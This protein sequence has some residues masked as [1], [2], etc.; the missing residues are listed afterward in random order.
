[1]L[2]EFNLLE[3]NFVCDHRNKH[4]V[5][6]EHVTPNQIATDQQPQPQFDII[7]LDQRRGPAADDYTA[8]KP[9]TPRQQPEY[10]YVIGPDQSQA[11]Q[12]PIRRNTSS[13]FDDGTQSTRRTVTTNCIIQLSKQK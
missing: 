10:Y 7:K 12:T 11:E 5:A 2:S 6:D 4:P 13:Y 1:M 9:E 3:K 8:L